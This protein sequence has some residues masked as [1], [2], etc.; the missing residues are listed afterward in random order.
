MD[1]ASAYREHRPHAALA[2]YVECYWSLQTTAGCATRRSDPDIVVPDGCMDLLVRPDEGEAVVVG[3]MT[4]PLIVQRGPGGPLLGVRFRP[5]G[6]QVALPVP[7]DELVDAA[8]SLDDVDGWRSGALLDEVAEGPVARRLER[9]ERLL[10]GQFHTGRQRGLDRAILQAARV[11]LV[12]PGVPMPDLAASVGLGR[13][14]FERRFKRAVGTSLRTARRVA[15][16]R[17]AVL[18]MHGH[19]DWSLSRLAHASGYHDQAHLTRDFRSFA[20][21]TPARYRG[22]RRLGGVA[23]PDDA[24]VQ[25][26]AAADAYRGTE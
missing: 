19:P 23:H 14:Q 24:S 3:T 4:R 9:V 10:L 12:R 7:A 18:R 1:P 13:R 11:G 6:I 20:G 26:G 17:R 21:E 22:R 15:R 16:F 5:A 2:P 25:D 8:V